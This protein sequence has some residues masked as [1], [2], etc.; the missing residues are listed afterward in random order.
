MR[1]GLGADQ[2]EGP[3]R[4]GVEHLAHERALARA[5]DPRDDGHAADGD[6][7]RVDAQVVGAGAGE[8]D[9]LGG[10]AA[11]GARRGDGELVREGPRGGRGRVGEH[12][13]GGPVGDDAPAAAAAG[14]AEIDEVVG[15]A[16]G[17]RVVLDHEHG[18]PHVRELAQVGEEAPRVARVQ[19]DGGLVEHVERAG[20]PAAELRREPQPLH[21]RRRR[22]WPR[23]GRGRGSRG[24]PRA[25][26]RAGAGARGAARR[27]WSCGRRRSAAS[28][29]SSAASA[30]ERRVTSW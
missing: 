20:E 18:A 30:T 13:G 22:A 26:S 27:R 4:G 25:R 3:A 15:G 29:P 21:L 16:D 2:A 6:A 8:L 23:A 11:A 24:R 28:S 12:L 14:G 10:V 7:Q 5:G 19:A 17:V 9:G 1:A